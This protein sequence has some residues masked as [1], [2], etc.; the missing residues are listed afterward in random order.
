M[1]IELFRL[2]GRQ[3]PLSTG[4]LI[5]FDGASIFTCLEPPAGPMLIP[6]SLTGITYHV[7]KQYSPRFQKLTP[8]YQDVPGHSFEEMHVGNF[9]RDTE[10]CTLL[11]FT[12]SLDFI[13]SSSGAFEDFMKLT[14]DEFDVTIFDMN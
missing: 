14:P 10:G 5:A 12:W 8:H 13:G 11:G 3:T 9:P 6:G 2:K 4:G 7:V 1:K